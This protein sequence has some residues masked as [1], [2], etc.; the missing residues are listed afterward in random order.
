MRSEKRKN[1]RLSITARSSPNCP[2]TP[3]LISFFSPPQ[4][5]QVSKNGPLQSWMERKNC[6]LRGGFDFFFLNHS[7]EL[8]WSEHAS[9][10]H[11]SLLARLK[12]A[13]YSLTH[14]TLTFEIL[15]SLHFQLQGSVLVAHKHCAG[16]LLEGRHGPHMVHSLL[17]GLVQSKRLV[18]T[19]DEDHHLGIRRQACDG[20]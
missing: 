13:T 8:Q 1:L 7:C 4:S 11:S 12:L 15:D 6:I 20:G 10:I 9:Q 18:S 14:L 2:R 19:C 3:T 5:K 17:D 16:M